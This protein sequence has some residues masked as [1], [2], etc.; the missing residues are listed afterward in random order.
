MCGRSWRHKRARVGTE[1]PRKIRKKCQPH[2]GQG[3]H[4]DS[5]TSSGGFFWR[6]SWSSN[7]QQHAGA[8]HLLCRILDFWPRTNE[9]PPHGGR[10]EKK[11]RVSKT[12]VWFSHGKKLTTGKTFGINVGELFCYTSNVGKTAML[13]PRGLCGVRR[14]WNDHERCT[15]L[16]V[17]RSMIFCSTW[18]SCSGEVDNSLSWRIRWMTLTERD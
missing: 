5:S 15:A 6:T 11:A 9:T 16:L 17:D 3:Q 18:A 13:C 14:S 7:R 10:L 8:H 2:A 1:G 4:A 12:S